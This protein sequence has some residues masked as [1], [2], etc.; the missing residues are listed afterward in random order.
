MSF[1]LC[2]IHSF[3]DKYGNFIMKW[4]LNPVWVSWSLVSFAFSRTSFILLLIVDGFSVA[5]FARQKQHRR[6]CRKFAEKKMKE[7]RTNLVDSNAIFIDKKKTPVRKYIYWLLKLS[8]MKNYSTDVYMRMRKTRDGK[9][10]LYLQ[11]TNRT[12]YYV[13]MF[14]NNDLLRI[15]NRNATIAMG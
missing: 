5:F 1:E 9:Q 12:A 13:N 4:M 15:K 3:P 14:N 6:R 2:P 11:H 10:Y 8:L 7:E